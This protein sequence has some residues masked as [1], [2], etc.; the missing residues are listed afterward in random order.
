[1]MSAHLRG[2]R[3]PNEGNLVLGHHVASDASTQTTAKVA[4]A[5]TRFF[6]MVDRLMDLKRPPGMDFNGAVLYRHATMSWPPLFLRY[7]PRS[8]E[9]CA[10]V[11]SRGMSGG[12]AHSTRPFLFFF[13]DQ[14]AFPESW[15]VGLCLLCEMGL[16][17][18]Q[19]TKSVL[20]MT[21]FEDGHIPFEGSAV[22][23]EAE[24]F[25]FCL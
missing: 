19:H 8:Q 18:L 21:V 13:E 15:R 22:F 10:S 24:N 3:K 5:W 16:Q 6:H 17:I 14:G 7:Y 4:V 12:G 23:L 9:W 25:Q 2:R 11:C 1:M 20:F